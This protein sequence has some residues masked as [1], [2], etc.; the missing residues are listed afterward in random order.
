M[1]IEPVDADPDRL[2]VSCPS[3]PPQSFNLNYP[4]ISLTTLSRREVVRRVVT[5]V[6]PRGRVQYTAQV[7]AP[8]GVQVSVKPNKLW[9]EEVGH[10]LEF[11]VEFSVKPNASTKDDNIRRGSL[12]WT[13]GKGGHKV[14]SP[15]VVK[16]VR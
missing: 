5:N 1:R 13:D 3:K 14:R 16:V 9:F 7:V 11:K 4:S 15:I 10:R 8:K 2:F 12:T 6:G